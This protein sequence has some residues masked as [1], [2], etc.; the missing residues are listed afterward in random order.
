MQR[1]NYYQTIHK[2]LRRLLFLFSIH[3]GR[4][5]FAQIMDCA[6]LYREFNDLSA[7]L[8]LHA[9]HEEKYFSPLINRRAPQLGQTTDDAHREQEATLTALLAEFGQLMA[10]DNESRLL[11]AQPLYLAINQFIADYLMHLHAEETV[12]MPQLWAHYS[13]AELEIPLR[14]LLDGMGKESFKKSLKQFLPAVN[15]QES[16]ALLANCSEV[17]KRELLK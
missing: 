6:A 14:Q 12:I 3:L 8:L 16:K 17:E 13:D 9:E 11:R 2:T 7:L 15:A 5:D 1:I 10:I 4:A